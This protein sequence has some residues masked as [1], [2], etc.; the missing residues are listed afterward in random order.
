MTYPPPVTYHRPQQPSRLR[1][2]PPSSFAAIPEASARMSSDSETLHSSQGY[3][4]APRLPQGQP[5]T[6]VGVASATLVPSRT[7]RGTLLSQT[8]PTSVSGHEKDGLYDLE[9]QEY[10][11]DSIMEY[12]AALGVPIE[13]PPPTVT[14]R[15]IHRNPQPSHD[16]RQSVHSFKSVAPSFISRISISH[17]VKR[18]L[19]WRKS[20]KPLPPVPLIPDIPLAVEAQ[21]R[22]ADEAAPLPELVNRA[23][24]LHGLLE[25]EYQHD[26][27]L[28]YYSTMK[29]DTST[30]QGS[31]QGKSARSASWQPLRRRD[32]DNPNP[33]PTFNYGVY[34][35]APP[36]HG[37]DPRKGCCGCLPQF[38]RRIWIMISVFGVAVL[39]VV[40]AVAVVMT[41]R[42]TE[43]PKCDSGLV[44]SLCNMN[45]TCVCTS[46]APCNGLA[47]NILDL[48]PT[49]N[50]QFSSN[51]TN[52]E[53]YNSLWF[54]KGTTGQKDC[55]AQS[56][57][58]DTGNVLNS[59]S[60]PNRTLWAQA[61]LLWNVVQ[62]Q[63]TDPADTMQKF[64]QGLPWSDLGS[65][66]GPTDSKADSFTSTIAGYTY[67][68]AAQTLSRPSTSFVN[69]GRPSD[70]QASRVG[71]KAQTVL[72]RM[73]TFA[74][75]SSTQ[76]EIALENYWTTTLS[77]RPED[78]PTFKG[79]LGRSPI[80]LPFNG[81]STNI[82]SLYSSSTL[83][84]PPPL[85]CYPG[86]SPQLLQQVQQFETTVFNLDSPTLASAFDAACFPDRPIYGVL[87]LLQLRLPYLE[88]RP[89]LPRQAAVLKADAL[90][91][92]V[93]YVNEMLSATFPGSTLRAEFTQSDLDPRRYGTLNL[94]NHVILQYLSSMPVNVA[95]A[96]VQFVLNTAANP[97]VPPQPSSTLYQ[98][99]SSIPVLEVAVFGNVGPSDVSGTVSSFMTSTGSF[100]F[101][102]VAG[103]GLRN[104]TITAAAGSVAWA[105]NST[106]PRIVRDNSLAD[107]TID[108]AWRAVAD[109]IQRGDA[110]VG[111]GNVTTAFQATQKFTA[112]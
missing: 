18:M 53:V 108:Q 49:I 48:V 21:Y 57:L 89:W 23:G 35:T 58:V 98:S 15:R 61:A 87:D 110:N 71:P 32:V 7:I 34:A 46:S 4:G 73:Y 20:T 65:S 37:N 93:V 33:P 101:G 67:N 45:A 16:A 38:S 77:Q 99:L 103:S 43:T 6:V 54:A 44:G 68:F 42:K 29:S 55:S 111:L 76:R 72:D 30:Y 31:T 109:A 94:P 80:L 100:F 60:Y 112:I 59:E 97:A 27:P 5:P 91:R 13:P 106:A 84:F 56:L 11:D 51:F 26:R 25:K 62:T 92:A 36:A 104:W 9:D 3:P 41:K 8:F 50:Q 22:R 39:A 66:D 96:L 81:S 88:N 17:S 24:Q 82:R 64:V 1:A 12:K 79:V 40:I 107:A 14:Q 95:T 102:T 105:E 52:A 47:Q 2:A 74:L 78:L 83:L 90:P 63:D 10:D 85:A 69:Q 19:N 75:A 86:F 70:S 28:S